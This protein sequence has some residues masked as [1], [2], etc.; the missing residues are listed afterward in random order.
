MG[1]IFRRNALNL[2]LHVMQ[3]PEAVADARDDDEFSFDP[4]T[5]R[6]TNETR[7][8]TY[9]PVPLTPKED[10][11]RRTG[12]IVSVGRRELARL[13]RCRAAH[14][15]ARSGARP[16][17][18]HD[19]ADPLGAPRRQACRGRAR[20]DAQGLCRPAA[21][22]GRH[23]AFRHPHLQSDHRRQHHRS[24]AGGDRQRSLRLH[25]PGR[26]RQADRASAGR[27]PAS[28]A[29]TS[30]TTRRRATASSTS[31]FPNRGWSCPD[32]SFPAPIRTAAPTAPTARWG[33]A[34]D[35]RR[36]ASAGRRA[37]SS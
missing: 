33:W 19:R 34:S 28:T 8:K 30:R 17:H 25:R 31:T 14:R 29:S 37:T 20:R 1:D 4:A 16:P 24:A 11:I 12:G 18:D 26:R 36:S 7:Q 2:G 23:R 35:R 21:G 32:S 3:S 6:L 13:G 22:L 27:S 15:V 9:E 10:D 5:R